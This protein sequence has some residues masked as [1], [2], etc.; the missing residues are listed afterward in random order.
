MIIYH[1]F[2]ILDHFFNYHINI[3]NLYLFIE[4]FY[5]LIDLLNQFLIQIY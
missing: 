4:I 1:I 5:Y 2:P 3:I